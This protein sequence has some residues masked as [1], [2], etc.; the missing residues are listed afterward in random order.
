MWNKLHFYQ[1]WKATTYE[2]FTGAHVLYSQFI[3]DICSWQFQIFSM[4]NDLL[5]QKLRH[6][7]FTRYMTVYHTWNSISWDKLTYKDLWATLV[8]QIFNK[9]K[10]SGCRHVWLILSPTSHGP[11]TSYKME[12]L[13]TENR[14]SPLLSSPAGRVNELAWLTKRRDHL[15][16]CIQL[17]W[18]QHSG[19][20]SVTQATFLCRLGAARNTCQQAERGQRV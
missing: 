19:P 3:H 7:T 1:M 17:T 15:E 2:I 12:V 6:M 11:F 14:K 16:L 18:Q 9:W 5:K 4:L 20:L 13:G 8:I 10:K